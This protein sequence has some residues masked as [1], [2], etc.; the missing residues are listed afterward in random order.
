MAPTHHACQKNIFG[1]DVAA[2]TTTFGSSFDLTY[3]MPPNFLEESKWPCDC[4]NLDLSMPPPWINNLQVW[5]HI[6]KWIQQSAGTWILM[7]TPKLR[8]LAK[9]SGMF[10]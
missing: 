1:N 8:S 2:I 10:S 5:T 7:C 9:Q 3:L 6:A 4:Y